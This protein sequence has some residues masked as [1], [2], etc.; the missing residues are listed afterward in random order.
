MPKDCY[1]WGLTSVSIVGCTPFQLNHM[2]RP[3]GT[4]KSFQRP[5]NRNWRTPTRWRR[6]TL[7]RMCWV[8]NWD[9]H[10]QLDEIDDPRHP[11]V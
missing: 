7:L 10:L 11:D 9:G 4:C 3:E 2:G 1:P 6:R 5:R 8:E